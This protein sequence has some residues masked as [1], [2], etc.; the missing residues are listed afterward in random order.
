MSIADEQKTRNHQIM[1]GGAYADGLLNLQCGQ[2]LARGAGCHLRKSQ[3]STA[4]SSLDS[5][6]SLGYPHPDV[7]RA[8]RMHRGASG[9]ALTAL[10]EPP[11]VEG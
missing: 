7:D 5:G 4:Y 8:K 9:A 2:F 3:R 6:S 10:N 11:R 1:I